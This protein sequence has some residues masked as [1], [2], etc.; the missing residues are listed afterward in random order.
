MWLINECACDSLDSYSTENT[1]TCTVYTCTKGTVCTCTSTMYGS[2]QCDVY[3]HTYIHVLK[4]QCVRVHQQCMVVTKC[5]YTYIYTCTKGT[6]CTCT[7]TM[8]GSV[9]CDVYTHTYIHVLKVQCVRV[10]Q[11]CMV[12]HSV[13]YIHIHIYM[14]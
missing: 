12:V 7:S 1:D 14:Y 5:T 9:Q 10:H 3:T 4:V 8:Y 13:M 6:V 2:A 11:Q